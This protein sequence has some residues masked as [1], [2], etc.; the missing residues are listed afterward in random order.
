MPSARR[1]DTTSRIASNPDPATGARDVRYTNSYQWKALNPPSTAT[2]V[3]SG[4]RG[5]LGVRRRAHTQNGVGVVDVNRRIV[6]ELEERVRTGK[7]VDFGR[8]KA[9]GVAITHGVGTPFQAHPAGRHVGL[10]CLDAQDR[11]PALHVPLP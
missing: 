7:R 8:R 3:S 5:A 6:G 1:C 9:E 2:W 11:R 4:N 10:R